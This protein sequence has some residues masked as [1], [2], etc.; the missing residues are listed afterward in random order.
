MSPDELARQPAVVPLPD[1]SVR[2]ASLS[3][4]V[5]PGADGFRFAVVVPLTV[6]SEAGAGTLAAFWADRPAGSAS[7]A[8]ARLEVVAA[9]AERLLGPADWSHPAFSR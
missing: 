9:A 8:V 7:D 6:Q 2:A 4:D 1:A 5:E 3:Y